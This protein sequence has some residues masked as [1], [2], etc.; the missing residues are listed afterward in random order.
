M[1]M[2]AHGLTGRHHSLTVTPESGDRLDQELAEWVALHGGVW[3]GTATE[4]ITAVRIATGVANNF[5]P[6]SPGT[7]YTQLESRKVQLRSLGVDIRL[8]GGHPRTLSLQLC[9]RH[10]RKTPTS[11]D[12]LVRTHKPT[13]KSVRRT[14]PNNNPGSAKRFADSNRAD[15]EGFNG[16]V[17]ENTG[18]AL[19]AISEMRRQIREQ[20][21]D[22]ESAISCVAGRTQEITRCSGVAIGLLRQDGVAYAARAGIAA[23]MTGLHFH[24]NL[25]QSCL[26]TGATLQLQDAKKHPRV[27]ATCR[28]EGIGSLI[29]VPIF[30]RNR[31]IAG[32]V[33]LLFKD[34]RSFSTGHLMDLQLIA[35]VVGDA[36]NRAAQI[37]STPAEK[38]GSQAEPSQVE[39]VQVGIGYRWNVK[40]KTVGRLIR[41]FP[42]QTDE[43]WPKRPANP[44]SIMLG[45]LA[46][47]L[48]ATPALLWSVLK[49]AC[50]GPGDAK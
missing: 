25:F 26:R 33:E 48:A 15:G 28:R 44:D 41:S 17:F 10:A 9:D 36:L 29:I 22:L 3:R 43:V 5:W 2:S 19:L 24:A 4:L 32:A 46:S 1:T 50:T 38:R 8:N 45:L 49:R 40:A 11:A 31:E 14:I 7:L 30:Y 35:G 21:L 16:S 42:A 34:M 37:E 20:D 23:T 47:K 12:V 6:Q 39:A 13:A 27:G 18:E